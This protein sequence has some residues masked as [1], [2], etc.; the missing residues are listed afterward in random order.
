MT[1]WRQRSQLFCS[2]NQVIGL[3]SIW[4]HLTCREIAKLA[5]R[6]IQFSESSV[7]SLLLNGSKIYWDLCPTKRC[8][9]SLLFCGKFQ[10]LF[11]RKLNR[12][13]QH[14]IP[15]VT[16][17]KSRDV[18]DLSI[19]IQIFRSSDSVMWFFCSLFS[20]F[21]SPHDIDLWSGGVSERAL[22]GSLLGPTFACI[23]ASQFSNAR[24]GDRYWYEMDNQPSSFSIDQLQEIRKARLSRVLCDNTDLMETVQLYPFYLPDHEM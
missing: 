6:A 13:L 1:L 9:D 7:V 14:F 23:I 22:P 3:E 4:L 2:P 11:I 5:Y 21:R 10:F 8:V 19:L 20:L 16:L 12:K 15:W 24:A 17:E 18:S